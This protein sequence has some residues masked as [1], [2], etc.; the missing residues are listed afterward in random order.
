MDVL[1]WGGKEEDLRVAKKFFLTSRVGALRVL[2]EVIGL[3]SCISSC[4]SDKS[5]V[6]R[7]G[8]EMNLG[9]CCLFQDIFKIL[10]L[11]FFW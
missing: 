6:V 8:V 4:Y 1:S 5:L 3:S 10:S 7:L 2:E 9:R 11:D